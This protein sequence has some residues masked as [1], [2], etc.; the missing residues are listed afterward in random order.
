MARVE[1]GS[2]AAPYRPVRRL[3]PAL[4]ALPALAAARALPAD[5]VGLYLRLAAATAVVLIPGALLARALVL[6]GAAPALALSLAALSAS[7]VVTFVVHGSLWLTLAALGVV[8]VGALVPAVRVETRRPPVVWVGVLVAGA[9]FGVALWHVAGQVQ[10][11][12]LFHLARVR[13]LEAFD[14]L[15]LRTLDEF[16][17]GGLHPGYAFPLWHGFLAL[18]A[19]LAD[20]DPTQVVLHEP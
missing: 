5:G 6:P 19:R 10:G 11:D 7:L 15:S 16:R 13:K 14:N 9:A 18:V 3:P 17:D 4:L 1:L 8:A 20:V 12:G 2:L